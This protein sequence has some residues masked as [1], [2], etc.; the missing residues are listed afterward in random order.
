[1]EGLNNS[2]NW[3][4]PY[5]AIEITEDDE[6]DDDEED[7]RQSIRSYDAETINGFET[8]STRSRRVSA[9]S[10]VS[11][12]GPGGL[13]PLAL[14]NNTNFST[15]HG[16]ADRGKNGRCKTNKETV[17]VIDFDRLVR[18]SLCSQ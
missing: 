12:G 9:D 3:V 2:R 16:E 5:P 11:G 4:S 13:A 6:D 14:P 15:K 1:M 10:R 8:I 17:S 18:G 7:D